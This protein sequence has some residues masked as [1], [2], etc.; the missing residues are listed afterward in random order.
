MDKNNLFSNFDS[1]F[2]DFESYFNFPFNNFSDN[3]T[4]TGKDSNG[5]W[6]KQ[7]FTS[8]DG[9]YKITTFMRT[10][11]KIPVSKQDHATKIGDLKSQMEICVEKQEFEMAAKLRDQIK[12]IQEN[13]TKKVAL[14]KE[15]DIAVK[16]QNFERAIEIRDELKKMK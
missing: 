10:S 14:S 16:E 1:F 8:K 9:S 7:T 5:E 2:N 4:E 3:K 12:S 15:L 6:L 13:S 11:G